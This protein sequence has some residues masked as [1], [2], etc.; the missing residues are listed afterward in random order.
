MRQ[1]II[2]FFLAFSVR[3]LNLYFHQIDDYSYLIEDQLMYWD[4]SIKNA[5]TVNSSLD[6]NLL[7][8]RMPGSFLFF[9]FAIWLAG[10]NI[11]NVLVIQI[12]LDSITCIIIACIARVINKNL[13][14]LAGIL[15]AISPLMII[16]SS[17]IL[18]D[19]IFLF[20]FCI[21]ILCIL[22]FTKYKKENSI[23]LGALFLGLA[24]C[25]RAVVLPFIFLVPFLIIFICCRDRFSILKI[26][27]IIS[28]FISISLALVIPRVINNYN[29][30]NTF[31]LTSQAGSHFAY[32][33]LPAILDFDTEEKQLQYKETLE[34]LNKKLNIA[35]TPFQ[36]SEKLKSEAFNFLLAT[37]KKHI[38][39]AW[40]KGV[41]L[42]ILSPPFIIDTRIRSLPHPS[43]YGN[44]RNLTRWLAKIFYTVE[45]KK[46]M[47]MLFI[48]TIFAL[49]FILLFLHGLYL[50]FRNHLQTAI[51]FTITGL[52]FLFITGPVFSPKY[53]HPILPILI[54][55]EA[56]SIKK[57]FGIFVDYIKNTKS[58]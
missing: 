28:I 46:Y 54:I 6:P 3:L 24:L 37:E 20:F 17:Q 56:F 32:W 41:I 48:S 40:S 16:I 23:Y 29:N 11:F 13:F 36:R 10:E 5:Y 22:I 58:Y 55:L 26:I 15:S 31:S 30:F 8:E 34:D 9:Q 49:C 7:L 51:I 39:L 53:I 12:F 19:T 50:I 14:V 45:F 2:I 52:Y 38:L 21:F 18:S 57:I 44:D 4:W 25:T 27:R 43:F 33:V 1:Y 35:D 47:I 42:N